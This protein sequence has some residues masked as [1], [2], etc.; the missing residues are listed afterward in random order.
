MKISDID[1]NFSIQGI[2]SDTEIEYF[3]VNNAPFSVFGVAFDGETY[4]RMPYDKAKDVSE[5]VGYL[6]CNSAGGRVAFSTDSDCIAI[7]AEMDKVS[8]MPH[9]TTLGSSGFDLYSDG[10]YYASF[11]PDCKMETGYGSIINFGEKK[12]RNILI[13]FPL[14]SEVKKLHI[15]LKPNSVLNEY[16]PYKSLP[17]IVYYGSSITQG[18]CASRPGNAYQ[19]EISRNNGIDFI[20]LG[21]SGSAL[22]EENMAQY[23]A[24]LQMTAFVLDYDHN[25]PTV[26]HLKNTHEKFYRIIRQKHKDLPVVFVTRP[27]FSGTA[28]VEERRKIVYNTYI[29]AKNSGENVAFVDGKDFNEGISYDFGTVDGSHPNDLSFYLMAVKIGKAIDSILH[30]NK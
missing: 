26:E 29:Q 13:N 25:A 16:N 6:A 14:Y 27:D 22:G 1:V 18:G 2:P 23:I 17:P 3:D 7:I 8:H 10:R 30:C 20:N 19:A 28:T 21:F 11:M 9:F 24:E 5:S 12:K 4:K 15:G